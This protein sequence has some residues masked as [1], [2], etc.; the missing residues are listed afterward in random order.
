MQP[1]R[2]G[3]AGDGGGCGVQCYRTLSDEFRLF[4]I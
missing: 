4:R 2:F 3:G 1:F